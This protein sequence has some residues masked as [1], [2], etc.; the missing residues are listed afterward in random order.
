M[1]SPHL[2]PVEADGP[3]LGSAGGFFL[4]KGIVSFFLATVAKCLL[5]G[6]VDFSNSSEK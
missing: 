3:E 4:L 6:N 5:I 1:L 2:K